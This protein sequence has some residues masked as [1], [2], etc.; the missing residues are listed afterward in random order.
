MFAAPRVTSH[1]QDFKLSAKIT[2]FSEWVVGMALE[3]KYGIGAHRICNM[4][5]AVGKSKDLVG[6]KPVVNVF[7]HRDAIFTVFAIPELVNSSQTEQRERNSN[8]APEVSGGG[9]KAFLFSW[10]KTQTT[11]KAYTAQQRERPIFDTFTALP[12]LKET[13][14]HTATTAPVST[15]NTPNTPTYTARPNKVA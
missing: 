2:G 8:I 9:F 13:V 3:G 15:T 14:S 11:N 6:I 12:M 5:T 4:Y 7:S 10:G 1:S